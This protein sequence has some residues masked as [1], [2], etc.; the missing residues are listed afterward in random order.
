MMRCV[1][2]G[3]NPTMRYIHRAF[4]VS[5]VWLHGRF[6]DE[7]AQLKLLSEVGNRVRADIYTK[8]FTDP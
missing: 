8:V 1:E 2:T 3:R 5:V 7:L 4:R 6:D